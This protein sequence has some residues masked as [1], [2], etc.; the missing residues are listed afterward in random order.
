MLSFSLAAVGPQAAATQTPPHTLVQSFSASTGP[1]REN[2]EKSYE[3]AL[4]AV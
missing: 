4:G 1:K 3:I 2:R